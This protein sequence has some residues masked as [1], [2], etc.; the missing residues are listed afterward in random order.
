M[1]R[2]GARTLLL[3]GRHSLLLVRRGY[4]RGYCVMLS[5][6]S[7]SRGA[8]PPLL[9]KQPLRQ[10][11]PGAAMIPVL[12]SPRSQQ[13]VGG[14]RRA[15]PAAAGATIAAAVAVALL[16]SRAA[17]GFQPPSPQRPLGP[18]RAPPPTV[19]VAG[20]RAGRTVPSCGWRAVGSRR[21]HSSSGS[22]NRGGDGTS[23][24]PGPAEPCTI[25]SCLAW[26][27]EVRRKSEA[28]PM[29]GS[30]QAIDRPDPSSPPQPPPPPTT[31]TQA[32]TAAGVPDP[33]LSAEY[34]L[35]H[36]LGQPASA[37]RAALLAPPLRDAAVSG[38]ALPVL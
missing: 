5:G 33:A 22:S 35:L 31:N 36:A 25:P 8:G 12:S 38:G 16:S 34:L 1:T 4:L 23:L 11:P 10:R 19:A 7:D 29:G 13:G 2:G 37:P 17:L 15:R 26:A 24:P 27:T 14:R 28:S 32:F 3:L 18:L 21:L 30:D 9:L 6:S 20:A